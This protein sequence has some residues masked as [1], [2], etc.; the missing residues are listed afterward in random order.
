MAQEEREIVDTF[1]VHAP[2]K[3]QCLRIATH[4]ALGRLVQWYTHKMQGTVYKEMTRTLPTIIIW[5]KKFKFVHGAIWSG[6]LT[7]FVQSQE[8]HILN[9]ERNTQSDL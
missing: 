9:L 1:E 8:K 4:M 6:T 7:Y 5:P 2:D 3:E